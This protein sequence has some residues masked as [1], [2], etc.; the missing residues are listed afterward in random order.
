MAKFK[1]L[2]TPDISEDV[3]AAGNPHSLVVGMKF[4]MP[5]LEDKNFPSILNILL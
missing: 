1:T 5:T 3:E 4:G 2:R